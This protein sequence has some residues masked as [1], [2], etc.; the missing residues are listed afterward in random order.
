MS[1]PKRIETEREF[2]TRTLNTMF[3]GYPVERWEV[4]E[5]RVGTTR[6]ERL[7]SIHRSAVAVGSAKATAEGLHNAIDRAILNAGATKVRV[8]AWCKEI[9]RS[10]V[11]QKVWAPLADVAEDDAMPSDALAQM[12]TWN[13]FLLERYEEIFGKSLQAIQDVHRHRLEWQNAELAVYRQFLDLAAG[14]TVLLVSHRLG[15]ARL[16]DR[17]G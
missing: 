5:K 9:T 14:K 15:S 11:A 7:E 6:W 17:I 10:Q 8:R 3:S 4:E 1:K 2:C 16:A 12:V 13:R